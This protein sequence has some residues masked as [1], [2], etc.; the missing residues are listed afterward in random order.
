MIYFAFNI[1]TH[2]AQTIVRTNKVNNLPTMKNSTPQ[3]CIHRK[4]PIN[5]PQAGVLVISFLVWPQRQLVVNKNEEG[6]PAMKLHSKI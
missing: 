5:M 4:N 2:T 1:Y 6:Y 3:P